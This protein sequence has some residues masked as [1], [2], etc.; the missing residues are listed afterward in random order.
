MAI[1]DSIIA[2]CPSCGRDRRCYPTSKGWACGFCDRIIEINGAPDAAKISR[3]REVEVRF[4]KSLRH[5]A[6]THRQRLGRGK[7]KP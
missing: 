6:L 7:M 4:P 1:H 5:D 2:R 3:R